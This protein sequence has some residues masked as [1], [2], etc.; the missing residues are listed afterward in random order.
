[1]VV[2]C[3]VFHYLR[4]RHV[5][6]RCRLHALS[7]RPR[8]DGRVRRPEC[9]GPTEDTRPFKGA[10]RLISFC[11]RRI[12]SNPFKSGFDLFETRRHRRRRQ[13]RTRAPAGL[14]PALLPMNIILLD[15]CCINEAD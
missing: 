8:R 13:R 10:L 6:L 9:R 12:T 15:G 3:H 2:V 14:P 7:S 1:M 5:P 4:F 11:G